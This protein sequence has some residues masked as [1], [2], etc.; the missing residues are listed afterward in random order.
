M[1]TI[2]RIEQLFFEARRS[3]FGIS[4]LCFIGAAISLAGLAMLDPELGIIIPILA[5]L[6]LALFTL[7]F[8]LLAFRLFQPISEIVKMVNRLY[9]DVMI[10]VE[11]EPQG[12]GPD[13][14][15]KALAEMT[16]QVRGLKKEIAVLKKTRQKAPAKK[17]DQVKE[18]KEVA[19]A[20]EQDKF[21]RYLIAKYAMFGALLCVIVF[22][23]LDSLKLIV[24]VAGFAGITAIALIHVHYEDRLKWPNRLRRPGGDE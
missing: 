3:A 9:Q 8:L 18:A 14:E 4:F 12:A 5:L 16:K 23:T 17:K 15:R 11:L 21:W 10:D 22:I 24:A 19:P 1:T 6:V 7:M 13:I 2:D 20:K